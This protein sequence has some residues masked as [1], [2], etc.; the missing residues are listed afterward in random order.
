MAGSVVLMD[1]SV[2]YAAPARDVFLELAVSGLF[3]ARWT[4]R[5]QDEWSRH[6]LANRP[7]LHAAQLLRTRTLMNAH[8]QDCLVEEDEALTETLRL[9]DPDDRHVLAAALTGEA[10]VIVTFNLTDFPAEA[11]APYGITAQHPDMFLAALLERDREDVV[12]AARRVR[13][14]LCRPPLDATAYLAALERCGLSSTASHLS[15]FSAL[16]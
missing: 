4:E 11:L 15:A 2:L 10:E 16:L 6:L 14:R 1:A 9:P 3:R 8:A 5:I 13:A 7:D 12:A